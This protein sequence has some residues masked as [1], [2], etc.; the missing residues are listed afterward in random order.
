MLAP[1]T[2]KMPLPFFTN[3]PEP[4]MMPEKVVEVLS[5]P[6]V[7][8]PAPIVTAPPPARDP[9]VWLKPFAWSVAPLVTVTA[10]VAGRLLATPSRSVPAF[11]AVA[12]V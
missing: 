5:P 1:L 10:D 6:V 3:A 8:F 2:V 12:P 9:M 7:R 11:T 4:L